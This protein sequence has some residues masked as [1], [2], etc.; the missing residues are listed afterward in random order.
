MTPESTAALV[1][2]IVKEDS[3]AGKTTLNIPVPDKSTVVNVLSAF[4]AC[5]YLKD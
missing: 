1:E 5:P 3:G 2:A 4:S